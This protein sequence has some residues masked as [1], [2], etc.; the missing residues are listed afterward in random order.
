MWLLEAMASEVLVIP[1]PLATE[2]LAR[3][4]G[5]CPHPECGLGVGMTLRERRK[6]APTPS[7]GTSIRG[8]LTVCEELWTCDLCGGA[9]IEVVGYEDAKGRQAA[10]IEEIWRRQIWPELRPRQ[11]HDD[12]PDLIRELFAEASKA[13]N[14]G[15]RR[16]AGVGYRAVVEEI[17]KDQGAT[18]NHLYGKINEL[19]SNG[20]PPDVIS[21]L[22]EGRIVGNESIHHSVEFSAP[23]IEDVAQLVEEVVH[24]LYVEP[25]RRARMAQARQQRIAE[26]K[27]RSAP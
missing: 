21:T 27:A 2:Q 11:L 7:T 5:I 6:I 8:P 20:V 14:T 13:Q 4:R 9:I 10:N 25:A 19:A 16:L 15:A 24:Y 3:H 22:H 1:D 23:E 17:C 18:A 26:A 12:A